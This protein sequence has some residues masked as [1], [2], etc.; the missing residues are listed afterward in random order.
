MDRK[1][2]FK[3]ILRL[4]VFS[5]IYILVIGRWGYELGRD[6]QIQAIGY[7]EMIND[8]SLFTTD[9]YLQNI[10]KVK[11]NER[12][13]FSYFMSF[14]SG[15]YPIYLFL[16]HYITSMLL[17]FG[18]YKIAALYIKNEVLRWLT[19]PA[20]FI[21]LYL[22]YLGS[23]EVYYPNFFVSIF[24]K[25][26]GIWGVYLFL[27]KYYYYAILVF[28]VATFFHQVVGLQ[29][30]M[31]TTGVLLIGKLFYDLRID[32]IKIGLIILTYILTAGIWMIVLKQKFEAGFTGNNQELFDIIFKFR[33]PH[34]YLPSTFPIKQWLVEGVLLL[35]GLR[36]F[37][38]KSQAVFLFYLSVIL[39]LIVY[40]IGV[41]SFNYINI[42]AFQWFKTTMWLEIFSVIAFFALL[43]KHLPFLKSKIFKA[44]SYTGVFAGA[45]IVII[46]VTS[47]KEKIPFK[48]KYDF[49]TQYTDDANVDIAIKIKAKTSKDALF[50]HPQNYTELRYYAERNSFVDYKIM[51]LRKQTIMLWWDRLSYIYGYDYKDVG[52]N[53]LEFANS[54]YKSLKEND[55]VK[56]KQ[57]GVGYILT[58][59][60]HKLNFPILCQNSKYVVY[61]I[62]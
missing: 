36:F 22:Y 19:L 45:I 24:V 43:E 41:E 56:L 15:N 21:P 20:L 4:L 58:F 3:Y 16:M 31:I 18:I 37:Y 33:L 7:A 17:F 35:I 52:I 46:T 28:I 44:L 25:T 51:P 48:V 14:F 29:L 53:K 8:S 47:F 60:E 39:G 42:T 59:K 50:V 6:D 49:G 62:E 32:W 2:V 38:Q 55:F 57:Y 40:T 61:T 5:A 12:F 1:K 26:I 54:Y 27:K 11:P 13:V 34:H 23:C 10:D 30:F 9:F